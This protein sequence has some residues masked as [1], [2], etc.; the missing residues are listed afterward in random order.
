MDLSPYLPQFGGAIFAIRYA[1]CRFA[2]P[3]QES[4]Q[5]IGRRGNPQAVA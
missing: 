2:F 1:S 3:A 4:V 5:W